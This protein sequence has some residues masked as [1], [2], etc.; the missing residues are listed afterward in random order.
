MQQDSQIII[1]TGMSGAGKSI[2]LKALEDLGFFCID[3]IPSAL[4]PTCIAQQQTFATKKLALGVDIRGGMLDEVVAYLNEIRQQK[5]PFKIIYVTAALPTLIKRFQETRRQH[6]LGSATDLRDALE[7]EKR[8]LSPLEAIADHV[9]ATDQLTIHQLRALVRQTFAHDDAPQMMVTLTSFGF[10]YGVPPENNFVFD[11]R[12]LPNPYFVPELK[13]HDGTSELIQSYLFEQQ[14]VQEYWQKFSEFVAFSLHNAYQ[15]GRFFVAVAVGCTG[16]R[17]RSVALVEKLAQL[18]LPH[19][20][21]FIKHRD[22][23]KDLE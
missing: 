5:T 16:G 6:P 18:P 1:V 20:Q 23:K 13:P 10:K 3:N 8:I 15:E 9:L 22:I 12:S 19:V 7:Q 17:H 2:V 11:V 4:L 21:F 14:V